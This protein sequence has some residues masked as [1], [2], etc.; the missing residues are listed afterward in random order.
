LRAGRPQNV[1]PAINNT[2]LARWRADPVGFIQRVLINPET[3]NRFELFD[4]EL[5][6][7]G[8]SEMKPLERSATFCESRFFRCRFQPDRIML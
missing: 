4:A 1:G 7:V 2:A 8:P 3:N 6:S 5:A